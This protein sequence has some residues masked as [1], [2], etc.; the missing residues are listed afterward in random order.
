[1][2]SR[3]QHE[4]ARL[5]IVD[6][7]KNLIELYRDGR[8]VWF[9]AAPV[10]FVLSGCPGVKHVVLAGRRD[11]E[12][13]VCVVSLSAAVPRGGGASGA[14]GAGDEGKALLAAIRSHGQDQGVPVWQL[15]S[16]IVVAKEP[17][18]ARSGLMVGLG[19]VSRHKVLRRY[20]DAIAETY[21][22]F[23]D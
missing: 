16:A 7:I 22:V 19:K 6:R 5:E 10:E 8:S 3:L 18:D 13:L 12:Q 4:C 23:R 2:S 1:M 20:A 17:W 21:S 11:M 15:P 14:S 9:N